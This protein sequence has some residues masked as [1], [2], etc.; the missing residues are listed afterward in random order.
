MSK[1]AW[2]MVQSKSLS[3]R[4]RGNESDLYMVAAQHLTPH[5]AILGLGDT[6][7]SPHGDVTGTPCQEGQPGRDVQEG[8]HVQEGQ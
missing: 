5:M 1:R 3:P 8:Q 4:C 2:F 6:A 7:R